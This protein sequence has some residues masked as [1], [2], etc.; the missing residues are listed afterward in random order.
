MSDQYQGD[1]KKITVKM[2][3]LML[4]ESLFGEQI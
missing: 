3:P 4:A 2:P 1:D